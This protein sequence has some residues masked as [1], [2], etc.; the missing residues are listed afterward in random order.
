MCSKP[1]WVLWTVFSQR[2]VQWLQGEKPEYFCPT[3]SKIRNLKTYVSHSGGKKPPKSTLFILHMEITCLNKVSGTVSDSAP[4]R[5]WLQKHSAL[6][7]HHLQE[8]NGK[9]SNFFSF[10]HFC[11]APN[12]ING[13]KLSDMLWKYAFHSPCSIFNQML[14]W[15]CCVF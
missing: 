8:G 5:E 1:V 2:C 13:N 3:N 12:S 6:H 9:H 10:L 11:I 14:C 15:L 7:P 4:G